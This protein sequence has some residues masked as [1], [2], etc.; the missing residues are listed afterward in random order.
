MTAIGHVVSVRVMEP[1]LY[2]QR[3]WY[4]RVYLNLESSACCIEYD[5]SGMMDPTLYHT[6]QGHMVI[7]SIYNSRVVNY[8]VQNLLFYLREA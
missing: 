7:P 1:L 3:T 5:R 4:V 6:P 2:T 8:G